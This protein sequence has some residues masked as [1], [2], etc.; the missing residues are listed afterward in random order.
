MRTFRIVASSIDID[1]RPVEFDYGDVFVVLRDDGPVP[2]NSDWEVQIRTDQFHPI[3]AARHDLALR[4]VDG[5]E[6]RGA[7]IVRFSDGHRHLFRG[8][9][10][11]D[12][13]DAGVDPR[14]WTD[15]GHDADG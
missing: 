8:D 7:A 4:A 10:P 6:V 2:A 5:S 15:D 13:F 1:G 14:P 11:L 12:G 3:T 9:S